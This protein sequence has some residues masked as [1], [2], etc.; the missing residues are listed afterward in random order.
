MAID[1]P[2]PPGVRVTFAALGGYDVR[3]AVIEGRDRVA[4]WD[5]LSRPADMRGALPPLDGRGLVVVY[6]HADWDHVWGTDGL[7]RAGARIVGHARCAERFTIDVP[8]TLSERQSAEP[9]QWETVVLVPPTVTFAE[10][11]SEDLGG[12]TLELHHLPG[13][14]PDCIVGFVPERGAWLGGDTV[15]TP[16]PVVPADAPLDAWIAGLER[17]AAD[18]RVRWVL[19]AHGGAGRRTILD[20]NL[21]YLRGIRDRRPIDPGE[22]LAPFYREAHAKNRAWHGPGRG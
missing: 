2:A 10:S 1:A 18:D 15:E 13:H 16:F 21:A 9:G 3:G 4:V 6:S 19:P 17:W 12:L 7:P 14:T 22:D 20:R 8:R 11:W 5:T